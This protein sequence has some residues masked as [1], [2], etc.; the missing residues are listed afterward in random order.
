MLYFPSGVDRKLFQWSLSVFKSSV[1]VETGPLYESLSPPHCQSQSVGFGVMGSDVAYYAAVCDLNS[2]GYL[3]L[4]NKE[5][6]VGAL[7]IPDSLEEASY[8]ICKFS[9]P[10]WFFGTLH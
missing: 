1:G 10:F 3:M 7:N 2:L 4:V 5:A 6:C 8:L 9:Y